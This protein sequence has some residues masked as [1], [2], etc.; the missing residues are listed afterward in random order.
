MWVICYYNFTEF[1]HVD[2]LQSY[3][4]DFFNFQQGF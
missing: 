2:K 3:T 1:L 4:L